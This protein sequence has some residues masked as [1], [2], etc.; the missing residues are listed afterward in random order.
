MNKR[1]D[2]TQSFGVSG[3]IL[4][5]FLVLVIAGIWYVVEKLKEVGE[6]VPQKVETAIQGCGL[7]AS[8]QTAE[9]YCNLIREI[10]ENKYVTC[11]YGV[12]YEGFVVGDSSLME[13]IC[14]AQGSSRV[15]S[16]KRQIEERKIT[17]GLI[18][19]ESISSWKTKISVV[20]GAKTS[21]E[22]EKEC[23]KDTFFE[24]KSCTS[25]LLWTK[26]ASD[27]KEYSCCVAKSCKAKADKDKVTCEA[28]ISKGDK[29]TIEANCVANPLCQWA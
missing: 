14:S 29:G 27:G 20:T 2:E 3:I 24:G 26:L 15:I 10:G 21:K 11:D 13:P 22:L 18:N 23:D 4:L 28:I 5:I 1:G 9:S 12:K 8:E 19:G 16:I 17:K 7:V 25:D 6:N